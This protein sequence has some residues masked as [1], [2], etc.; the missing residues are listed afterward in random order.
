MRKPIV[1]GLLLG[2][3]AA[4]AIGG[5]FVQRRQHQQAAETRAIRLT[6]GEPARGKFAIGRYGCGACHQIPGVPGARGKVGPPLEGLAE[7]ALVGGRLSN[8]G[9]NLAY[10]IQHPQQ[11]SPGSGM[12]EMGV[13]DRDARDIAAFLYA[14][15]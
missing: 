15:P 6:G 12:P 5:T 4:A 13:T 2:L 3:V 14:Q 9:Y 11:V 7:R 10:W 1:A 8:T